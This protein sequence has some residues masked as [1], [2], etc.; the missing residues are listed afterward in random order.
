MTR[1][2]TKTSV[3]D[4]LFVNWLD[5]SNPAGLGVTIA[6]GKHAVSQG[7]FRWERDLDTDL[8]T[9]RRTERVDVLV[10]M[11]PDEEMVRLRIPDLVSRANSRGMAVYRL[12]VHDGG[13]LPRVEPMHALCTLVALETR[14]RRVVVHCQGGLGRAGT[15]AAC[16]LVHQ[17]RTAEEALQAIKRARGP[18]APETPAQHDFVRRYASWLHDQ[19][20]NPLPAHT[21]A[22]PYVATG[23]EDEGGEV[24]LR[25]A[26]SGWTLARVPGEEATRL[27]AQANQAL[28]VLEHSGGSFHA[29]SAPAVSPSHHVS[30]EDAVAGAVL[31]AAVGDAMGHPT[32]FM[33]MAQIRERFGPRGVQGYEKL[34]DVGGRPV[35]P[36]TDDTQMA[37][38]VALALLD[39]REAGADLD[40]CMEGMARRFVAW[41][42]HPQGGHRAPGNACLAGC[43]A[44]K[45][46]TPWRLAGGEKAGGCGSVMRAYPFGLLFHQD[47]ARAEAWAV[48]H[49]RLTHRDPIALAACAAMAVGT[50]RVVQGQSPP[51]VTAA[52][53]EAARRHDGKTADMV[54][55]A[56]DEARAGVGP[57]VTLD[58]LRGWAAHEAIAAAVYVVERHPADARAAI[59][60]GANTPGDSDSIATLAGALVG[61]RVGLERIPAAWVRDVERSADLLA[62]ARRI[63]T[64]GMGW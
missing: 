53:V 35:A 59:L 41:A 24:T 48:D 39:A 63:G 62:L 21:A 10:N 16:W 40:A 32:E 45:A 28:G 11:L 6:P 51:E 14:H 17:G 5:T 19:P 56:A 7:G 50:A 43:R 47:V 34:W 60:E 29:A 9:L 44:L 26:P 36:Y 64:A 4:P 25:H 22:G 12:P 1:P 31:G 46:G 3:S 18:K 54:Q 33:S 52:M 57:E 38:A 13:V 23:D 61:A 2:T 42:D 30:T 55:Q 49:S 8:E 15:M 37:E 20:G 58:R 27:L